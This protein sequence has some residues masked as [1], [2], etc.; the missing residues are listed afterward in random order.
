MR[1]Y[2]YEKDNT[3]Q[4][5]T[6]IQ[7]MVQFSYF[8]LLNENQKVPP[9]S[10]YGDFDIVFC[11]NVLIYL[12]EEQQKMIFEKLY[13]SLKPNGFLVLGEAEVP[14]IEFKHNFRRLG[15]HCKIFKKVPFL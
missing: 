9:D 10:I 8:N 15:R 2:F 14:I 13:H 7:E 12:N 1:K 3:F 11:R 6:E 5:N 4:L